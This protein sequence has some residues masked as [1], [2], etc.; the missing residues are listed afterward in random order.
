MGCCAEPTMTNRPKGAV[1]KRAPEPK[2]RSTTPNKDHVQR[3]K[4]LA[5]KLITECKYHLWGSKYVLLSFCWQIMWT[6]LRSRCL[7]LPTRNSSLLISWQSSKR[8]KEY[9]GVTITCP[10]RSLIASLCLTT[11]SWWL[12]AILSS[13]S[14]SLWLTGSP[15]A[16][17]CPL[18]ARSCRFTPSPSTGL[19]GMARRLLKSLENNFSSSTISSVWTWLEAFRPVTRRM[20]AC[21]I[22]R[23]GI[24]QIPCKSSCTT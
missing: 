7:R 9:P 10:Q 2:K 23:I 19:S 17:T 20:I 5:T 4:S 15:P 21:S 22:K 24:A 12:F 3:I 11:S 14:I 13:S 8:S 18:T 6:H 16:E 1:G